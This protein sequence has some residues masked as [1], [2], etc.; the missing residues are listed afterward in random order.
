MVSFLSHILQNHYLWNGNQVQE[1]LKTILNLVAFW[2]D[3][4]QIFTKGNQVEKLILN[5]SL[6]KQEPTGLSHPP[7]ELFPNLT[8]HQKHL[9]TLIKGRK[10]GP[11]PLHDPWISRV[12]LRNLYIFVKFSQG[13]WWRARCGHLAVRRPITTLYLL[14]L[15]IHQLD[16][17]FFHGWS[18]FLC[19]DPW[20][21]SSCL[22]LSLNSKPWVTA[23]SKKFWTFSKPA[24][25][26]AYSPET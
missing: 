16:S 26:Q 25:W 22:M 20:Q 7:F 23:T 5:E 17:F 18:I 1:S 4:G 19:L 11:E 21:D 24:Q 13:C 8:D 2:R 14:Q 3:I 6:L 12:R 9:G 15:Q 10:M